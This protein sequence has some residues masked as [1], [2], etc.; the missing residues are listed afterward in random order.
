MDDGLGP[1]SRTGLPPSC[2]DSP[3]KPMSATYLHLT[4]PKSLDTTDLT[5]VAVCSHALSTR[6]GSNPRDRSGQEL[7]LWID[8]LCNPPP[9]RPPAMRH[10]VACGANAC[11]RKPRPQLSSGRG[12]AGTGRET[13]ST[14]LWIHIYP[15]HDA[16][17][18]LGQQ[19]GTRFTSNAP[20][21]TAILLKD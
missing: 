16:H 4:A 6:Y 7:S 19:V 14:S 21:A 5:R 3:A 15:I 12:E 20:D 2:D 1:S 10:R 11:P 13:Q 9:K 8:T 18:Q 17:C